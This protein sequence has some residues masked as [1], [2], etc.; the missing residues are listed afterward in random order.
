MITEQ[1]QAEVSLVLHHE[2][3]FA[4]ID[5]VLTSAGYQRGADTSVTAPIIPGEP[6]LAHWNSESTD[7]F[8]SYSFNPVVA[9]RVLTLSGDDAGKAKW[10]IQAQLHCLGRDELRELL[11]AERPEQVLRGLYAVAELKKIELLPIVNTLRINRNQRISRTAAQTA[12][13]LSLAIVAAGAEQLA[14]EQKRRP[15]HSVLF[16]RLGDAGTRRE[17]LLWLLHDQD[18]ANED[19]IKVLRTAL[20]DAD[21]KVRVTAMLVAAR[22]RVQEVWLD[23][24]RMEL[25]AT[26]RSG[27]DRRWRSLLG[28]MRKAA[29]A[30]LSAQPRPV[31][32]DERSRLTLHLRS[33]VAGE[34]DGI[35]DEPYHWVNGWLRPPEE[36]VLS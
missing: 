8:I 16:P 18:Q 11:Q 26:G 6:E 1:D 30:E 21:W 12:E 10:D 25:P 28:A 14:A 17:I 7:V 29:L 27:L 13:K 22:L 24:R 3:K 5:K 35:H 2:T 34:D 33:I 23:I 4:M 15:L 9:L 31:P 32:V 36:S 20:E 19:I